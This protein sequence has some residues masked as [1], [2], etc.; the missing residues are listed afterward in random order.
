[1][2]ITSGMLVAIMFVVLLTIG[3]GNI[4]M[5][6]ASMVDRRSPVRASGLHITWVVLLLLVYLG[7]FW[8]TIDVLSVD[9]WEFFAFLY[10]ILGPILI[11][12]ASQVLLP[13]PSDDGS[14]DL[15][16]F[17]FDVSRP[18]FIFLAASQIWVNGVDLILRD[19]LTPEG[20]LNGVVCALALVLAFSR[21]VKVH[22]M[23]TG[24]VWIL[25]LVK[26]LI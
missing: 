3:I 16:E 20:G 23:L 14:V 8:H 4:I 9:E 13:N 22:W 5:S 6:L 26:W 17:Y 24:V 1:M 18:F 11:I 25:F 21:N 7:F 2:D 10:V 15:N 19:G 12:F